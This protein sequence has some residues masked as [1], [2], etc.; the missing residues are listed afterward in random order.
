MK[1]TSLLLLFTL[2]AFASEANAAEVSK[3]SIQRI[4]IGT[5]TSLGGANFRS[6]TSAV[7]LERN[8]TDWIELGPLVAGTDYLIDQQNGTIQAAP[9]RSAPFWARITWTQEDHAE[10]NAAQEAASQADIA[11]LVAS[12]QNALDRLNQIEA[13]MT[14]LRTQAQTAEAT[15]AALKTV[16]VSNLAQGQAAIRQCGVL[17]EQ[18]AQAHQLEA[19]A[20]QDEATAIRRTLKLV[21]RQLAGVQSTAAKP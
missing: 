8:G 9:S 20:I 13:Q 19:S 14:A 12:Y 17:L 7:E 16:T 2:A 6:L 1:T 21:A 3:T 5:T 15:A 10:E 11:D 4:N 18:M